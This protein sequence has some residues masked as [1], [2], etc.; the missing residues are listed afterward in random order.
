MSLKIVLTLPVIPV[1]ALSIGVF[2]EVG[3]KIEAGLG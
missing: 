1:S 2:S 3:S